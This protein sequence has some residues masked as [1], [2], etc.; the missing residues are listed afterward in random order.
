VKTRD[1]CQPQKT[2]EPSP[3]NSDKL[4][5]GADDSRESGGELFVPKK[6]CQENTNGQGKTCHYTI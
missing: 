3:S 4:F 5:D 1:S 6:E 2:W